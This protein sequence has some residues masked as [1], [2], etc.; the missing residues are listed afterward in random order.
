[1]AMKSLPVRGAWIEIAVQCAKLYRRRSLPVR[2]AWI[3]MGSSACACSG[4]IASL[5][6]RGA[7][8]EMP[9]VKSQ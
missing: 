3:E 4:T 7:W 2:G 5:P 9:S 1:M 8:I 6:V